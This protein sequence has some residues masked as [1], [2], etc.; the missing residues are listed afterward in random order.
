MKT[1]KYLFLSALLMGFSMAANAQTGTA[2][3]VNAVKQL[4]KNKPA[5]YD[6]Q[7]KAF[8]K[9]NKKNPDQLVALGRALYEAADYTNATLF[10]N[11]AFSAKKN[12]PSAFNLLGDIASVS[13]EDGGKAASYYEQAIYFDPKDPEAYRKYATVYRRVS[14]DGAV[15][16]LEDL[17]QQRPD[18]PVD[19]LIAHINYLSMRYTA[20]MDAYANVLESQMTPQNYVEY[21]FSGYISKKYDKTLEVAQKGL[22]AYP[23]NATLT[24]LGLYSAAEQ[25][26]VAAALQYADALFNKIDKDSVKINAKDYLYYGRALENDSAFD[27]A[28]EAYQKGLA[29]AE[30]NDTKA[31]FYESLSD[32]YKGLKDFPN[33]IAQYDNYLGVLSEVDATAFAGKPN[34]YMSWARI[35]QGDEQKATFQKAD[36]MFGELMEKYPGTEEFGNYQRA[37]INANI[38][39]T[40]TEGLAKPYFEKL[41]ELITAR[42]ELDNTDKNRLENS[43]RYLMAY[44]VTITKDKEKALGYAKKVLELRPEDESVQRIIDVLS[45]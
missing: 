1:I 42:E 6:K 16:K 5:D 15:A 30:D 41:V 35:L 8:I 34:L 13:E 36:Q 19:A 43:Y 28:V 31:L 32:T 45:K 9:A 39:P 37:R 11:A 33:A 21:A 29:M 26:N 44:E 18:Y 2:A 25:K 27:K 10:A 7:L 14:I 22:K 40:M 20:T 17:R 23:N 24:R 12:F 38:D 3:D 4:V